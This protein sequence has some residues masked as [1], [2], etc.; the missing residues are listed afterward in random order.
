MDI[1][2]VLANAAETPPDE[3]WFPTIPV[4]L[5]GG[6]FISYKDSPAYI[7]KNLAKWRAKQAEIVE[8]IA[9]LKALPQGAANVEAARKLLEMEQETTNE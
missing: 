1:S 3:Q 6:R 8:A 4:S 5:A 7:T 2:T 9:T